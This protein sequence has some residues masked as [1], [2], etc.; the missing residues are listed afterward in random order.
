MPRLLFVLVT[1]FSLGC[2]TQE[3]SDPSGVEGV[4]RQ[5]INEGQY[6]E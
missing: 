6:S 5:L 1:A 3:P 2:S 4:W